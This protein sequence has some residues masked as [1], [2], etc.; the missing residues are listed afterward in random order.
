MGVLEQNIWQSRQEINYL[1]TS[2]ANV[3]WNHAIQYINK[4]APAK[5]IVTGIEV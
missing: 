5:N 4:N 1:L 2:N 3:E